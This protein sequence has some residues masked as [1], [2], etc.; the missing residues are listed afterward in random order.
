MK[1][2]LKMIIMFCLIIILIGVIFFVIDFNKIIKN[3]KPIFCIPYKEANDGGTI[4]YLGL[5]YKV[6][7]YNIKGYDEIEI[8]NLFIKYDDSKLIDVQ[9]KIAKENKDIVIIKNSEFFE[10][11]ASV[12]NIKLIDDFIEKTANRRKILEEISLEIHEY[13]TK[14]TYN[15]IKV[16]YTPGI[17]NNI[18]NEDRIICVSGEGD[19]FYKEQ[20][21]YYTVIIKVSQEVIRI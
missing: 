13:Y 1:K 8:G 9:D 21:G 5:G 18:E 3:E 2:I 4:I 19:E 17:L 6:I 14:E 7:D 11:N 12:E 10:S 16:I 15:I 20:F